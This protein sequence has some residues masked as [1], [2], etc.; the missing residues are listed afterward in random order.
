VKVAL[1]TVL[2]SSVFDLPKAC[3]RC[4]FNSRRELNRRLVGGVDLAEGST[5]CR[6]LG[7]P[8][9]LPVCTHEDWKDK[10]REEAGVQ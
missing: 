7:I 6:M 4:P 3:A 8:T 2:D 1:L 5:W 10:A 9:T